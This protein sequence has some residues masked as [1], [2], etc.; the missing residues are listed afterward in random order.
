M[1]E[2]RFSMAGWASIV[3]SVVFPL[4]FII[5][6]IHQEVLEC[7]GAEFTVGIGPADPLFLLF[8]ALSIYVLK[9]F[10]TLLYE[11]YS[12]REIGTII[13]VAIFWHIVFFGGSFLLELM[14]GTVWPQGHVGL[15]LALVVFYVTGIAV[16][17][18][19]DIIIGIILLRQK[20]RFSLP[21]RAFAW[22][23]IAMGF[24][25]ATVV[26]SFLALLLVPVSLIALAFVFLRR[27]D[28]VEFV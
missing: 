10:K 28:E 24:F 27:V 6:G 26:L 8:A 3:A 18:I 14:Y 23:S 7:S 21:I 25:E 5:D 11:Y 19:I 12:F 17:G 20:R 15:P 4:A 16:F 2:N 13:S 9:A 22:L 1:N